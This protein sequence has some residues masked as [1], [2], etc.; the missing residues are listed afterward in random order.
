MQEC[1]VTS[2]T[3]LSSLHALLK[4]VKKNLLDKLKRPT[5]FTQSI[6]SIEN[7]NV[8]MNEDILP[9]KEKNIKSTQIK[10]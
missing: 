2:P 3:L 7:A 10:K 1:K 6:F 9:F 4:K 8:A 5:L